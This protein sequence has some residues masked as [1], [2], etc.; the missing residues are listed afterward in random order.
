MIL[1]SA[2][3]NPIV[4]IDITKGKSN[5][6]EIIEQNLAEIIDVKGMRAQ[7]NRLSLHDVHGVELL[8]K[9]EDE[10]E[11]EDEMENEKGEEDT[12]EKSTS[13]ESEKVVEK[14]SKPKID[15]EITNPNEVDI[16]DKGQIEL[17]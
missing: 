12:G 16:G 3:S 1:I 13:D 15:L 4:K 8:T 10:L 5:I 17:F 7:G 2:A 11:L 14:S 9:D 6:E